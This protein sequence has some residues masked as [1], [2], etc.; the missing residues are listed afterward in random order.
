MVWLAGCDYNY[1]RVA[2]KK[3]ISCYNTSK[4]KENNETIHTL[5][6]FKG[7]RRQSLPK[8]KNNNN[9]NRYRIACQIFGNNNN[10]NIGK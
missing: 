7:T 9:N 5:L 3:Q 8:K 10:K 4:W 6:R 2:P 1:E